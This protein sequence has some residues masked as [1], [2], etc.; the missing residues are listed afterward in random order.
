M[1][2]FQTAIQ[3]GTVGSFVFS[4]NFKS[5][6]VIRDRLLVLPAVAQIDDVVMTILLLLTLVDDNFNL[7]SNLPLVFRNSFLNNFLMISLTILLWNVMNGLARE[8]GPVPV[9]DFT[10]G[11]ECG[12]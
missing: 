2:L 4:D 10:N 1:I 6:I 12:C 11:E 9:A 7:S 3:R 5:G 8:F